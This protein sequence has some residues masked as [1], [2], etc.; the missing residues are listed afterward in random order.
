MREEEMLQRLEALETRWRRLEARQEIEN[1]MGRYA[2][3]HATGRDRKVLDSLWSKRDDASFED[4][5]SGVYLRKGRVTGLEQY[6]EKVYGMP[7]EDSDGVTAEP[8]RMYIDAL[9]SPVIEVAADLQTAKGSWIT[10]GSESRVWPEEGG[11]GRPKGAWAFWVWSR[12]HVDFRME[13]GTWR[14]WHMHIYDLFRCPF[15][16]NWMDYAKERSADEEG[17]DSFLRVDAPGLLPSYPSRN[18]WEYSP[19]RRMPEH[20]ELP[21]PYETFR[22]EG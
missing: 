1:L 15:E 19:W 16:K 7:P 3:W 17:I 12:I 22:D 2:Q 21:E 13:E 10:V 18:F 11:P 9:T 5:F 4:R 14:I 20:V 6:Y 8:G